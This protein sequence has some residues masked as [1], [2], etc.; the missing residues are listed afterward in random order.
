[1]TFYLCKITTANVIQ[2][3]TPV[4]LCIVHRTVLWQLGFIIMECVS[5]RYSTPLMVSVQSP[6]RI[7]CAHAQFN[8]MNKLYPITCTLTH[9]KMANHS[10]CKVGILVWTLYVTHKSAV[11][12]NSSI[13]FTC[14]LCFGSQVYPVQPNQ[15]GAQP[16]TWA[17]DG[18]GPWCAHWPHSTWDLHQPRRQWW[19]RQHTMSLV[20]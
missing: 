16:Q 9:M 10:A 19:I 7:V 8:V 11:T 1:M 6:Q 17:T 20:E 5:K 12:K 4:R 2:K 15:F 14:S 3:M 13:N 18:G